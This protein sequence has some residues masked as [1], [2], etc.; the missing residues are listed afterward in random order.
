MHES[1]QERNT[2]RNQ[3]W[4]DGF[5][6]TLLISSFFA[7][8]VP[9][10]FLSTLGEKLPK[11]HGDNLVKG[12][13]VIKTGRDYDEMRTFKRHGVEIV[14]FFTSAC[15][16]DRVKCFLDRLYT[17]RHAS[18]LLLSALWDV[19][20]WGPNG[21]NFYVDNC[22]RLLMITKAN[23]PQERCFLQHGS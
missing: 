15:F 21:A 9:L 8:C 6:V 23:F 10:L 17:E 14:F 19:S 7:S 2:K 22:E 16:S 5:Q 13:G 20:R 11:Y 3:E 4:S 18:D 12:T 1:T